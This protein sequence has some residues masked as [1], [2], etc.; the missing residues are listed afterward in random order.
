MTL[1]I[2]CHLPVS[3]W[4]GRAAVWKGAVG[5]GQCSHFIAPWPV[6]LPPCFPNKEQ[7]CASSL[8]FC[9]TE[10]YRGF[11]TKPSDLGGQEAPE[12]LPLAAFH[13]AAHEAGGGFRNTGKL[14]DSCRKLLGQRVS[15]RQLLAK[16][17]CPSLPW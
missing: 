1:L 3:A 13:S 16:S 4:L 9:Q 17:T 11:C 8:A 14:Q 10:P 5:N 6:P 15:D 12:A 7:S 2:C